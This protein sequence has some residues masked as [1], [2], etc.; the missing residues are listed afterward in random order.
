MASRN[1]RAKIIV[2]HPS[3]LEERT[4]KLQKRHPEIAGWS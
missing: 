4:A 3:H 2:S 1:D